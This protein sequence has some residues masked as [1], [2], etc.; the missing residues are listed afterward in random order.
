[1]PQAWT[2]ALNAAVQAG[3]IPDLDPSSQSSPG[4]NPTYD[5]GNP[6]DPSICSATYQ[7]R[8]AGQIWDAPDGVLGLGFDDG[9]LVSIVMISV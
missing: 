1:M 2:D 4:A 9:P 5:G 7:C 3:K 6:N 8:I